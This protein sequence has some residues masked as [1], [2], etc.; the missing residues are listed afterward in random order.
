MRRAERL[1]DDAPREK[2]SGT[3]TVGRVLVALVCSA[4]GEEA[5]ADGL[6]CTHVERS[7][8]PAML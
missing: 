7:H 8:S 1:I 6:G 2:L 5:C 4:R 3:T